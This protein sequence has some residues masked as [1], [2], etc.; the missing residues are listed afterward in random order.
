MDAELRLLRGLTR[1]LPP[2]PK[3]EGLARHVARRF[4]LRRPRPPVVT[5]VHGLA[6]ELDPHELV[7]GLILFTPQLHDRRA[8]RFLT[9]QLRPGDVFLDLGAHIGLY[10]LVLARRVGPAGRVLAVEP[11]PDSFARLLSNVARNDLAQVEAVQ[12]AVSD[13]EETRTLW[14]AAR[15]NRGGSSFLRGAGASLEVRCLPVPRLLADRGLPV[16]HAAKL[17]LEGFELRVL[18]A[19]AE[20]VSPARMPRAMVVERHPDLLE[21]AGGDVARWLV[22][23]GWAVQ[24]AGRHD[25]LALRPDP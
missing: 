9:R 21:G 10:S 15:G 12:A 20:A 24:R 17:D 22:D 3:M 8:L 5:E 2:L 19:W 6:M 4:Y 13:R 7:D 14:L 1:R 11:E 25:L 18:Q 23:R 16:V